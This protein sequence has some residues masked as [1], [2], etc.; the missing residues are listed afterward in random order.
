MKCLKK[1]KL[2]I[3]CILL[4]I[5]CAYVFIF[6]F[7]ILYRV[8]LNLSINNLSFYL[9]LF[10]KMEHPLQQPPDSGSYYSILM[11]AY[12]LLSSILLIAPA[13][14]SWTLSIYLYILETDSSCFAGSFWSPRPWDLIISVADSLSKC[15]C[16]TDGLGAGTLFTT[17]A[18]WGAAN[19]EEKQQRLNLS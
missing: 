16:G 2:E 1:K 5:L 14:S 8:I 18:A 12:F 17:A 11:L 15:L 10:Q 9:L 19:A 7:F 4:F 6:I 3:F 13:A